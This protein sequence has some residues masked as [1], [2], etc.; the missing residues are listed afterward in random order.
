MTAG[1]RTQVRE[2]MSGSSYLAQN[3]LRVHVGLGGATSADR[4]DI[5]W[6]SGEVQSLS[7]VPGRQV[8]TIREPVPLSR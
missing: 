2:V 6:P 7:S 1:A 8:V 4:V 3:D 5:R